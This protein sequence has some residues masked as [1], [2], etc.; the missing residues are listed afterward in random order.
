MTCK[1][2][3]PAILLGEEAARPLMLHCARLLQYWLASI[4]SE[5]E[6]MDDAGTWSDENHAV[7][8]AVCHAFDCA[9]KWI[10][11]L[12]ERVEFERQWCLLS[13]VLALAARSFPDKDTAYQRMLDGANQGMQCLPELWQT[14]ADGIPQRREQEAGHGTR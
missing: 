14:V 4:S 2:K 1:T 12:P 7:D 9:S 3:N 13:G 10:A 5:Q 11:D 8:L 6:S